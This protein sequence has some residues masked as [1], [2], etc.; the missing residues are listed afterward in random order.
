MSYLI[1][2]PTPATPIVERYADLA[3]AKRAAD[4]L[5][6]AGPR[7]VLTTITTK[8]LSVM[9]GSNL[10]VLWAKLSGFKPGKEP[11]G[12]RGVSD[13]REALVTLIPEK[14]RAAAFNPSNKTPK[15]TPNMADET[16]TTETATPKGKSGKTKAARAA[17]EAPAPKGK[18]GKASKAAPAAKGKKGAPTPPTR[19]SALAGKKLYRVKDSETLTR[20][21]EGSRRAV[22]LSKIKDGVTFE[23]AIKAGAI[24]GDIDTMIKLGTLRAK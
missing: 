20:M 11:S 21:R 1:H 19:V 9:T 24:K 4:A 16:S 12:M 10:S 15:E 7:Y 13:L 6:T 2:F 22:S 23:D 3:E 17:K 8:S 18:A 14:A 5:T